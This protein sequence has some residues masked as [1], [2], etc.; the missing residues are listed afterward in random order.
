MEGISGRGLLSPL[1]HQSV[2]G[3][4]QVCCLVFFSSTFHCTQVIAA[5]SRNA[6]NGSTFC[7]GKEAHSGTWVE[8]NVIGGA[9]NSQ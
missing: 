1:C 4:G 7:L 3:S 2:A 5:H 8:C 6:E 9:G